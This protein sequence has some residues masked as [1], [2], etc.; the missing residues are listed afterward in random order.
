MRQD[1][2]G[3][4]WQDLPA[5]PG[6]RNMN[7]VMAPIPE[8]GWVTPR[9]FPNLSAAPYIS[10]DTETKDPELISHGPG[11]GRGKGHVVG[12]SVAVPGQAWYFPMRHEVC[13][14]ENM[15]PEHVLAWARDT[16]SNPAQP[17][18]GANLLYDIGWLSEEGVHVQG[19]AHDVQFAESLL[20]EVA[21]VG[22][23][24]LG[25]KY[26]AEGKE[27]NVMYQWSADSYGG[28]ANGDQRA[29]IYRTPPRLVGPYAEEDALLPAKVMPYQWE[30]LHREGLLGL[31]DM[32]CRLIP[33]LIA[34]RKAG[35]AVNISRAEQVRDSLVAREKEISARFKGLL[36]FEISINSASDIFRAFQKLGI[37]VPMKKGD[38]GELKKT[39]A[40]DYL[41]AVDHP[42]VTMLMDARRIEK[43]RSTFIESYILEK[44]VNGK[45]HCQFHP[46]RGD[47]GGARSGRFSSADPNLQNVPIRD[48]ELGPLVR[49]CFVPDFGHKQWRRYDYSQIEYRFMAHF[50]V[51]PGSDE[52]RA[53][54]NNDPDTDYHINTQSLVTNHTGIKV[55]RK[56][57]KN[58]NFGLTF[59]MGKLRL[60]RTLSAELKLVAGG[61]GTFDG[62]S[63]Y[64]AYHDAVPFT[65][66]TLKSYSDL[67][68]SVGFVSTILGRRSRFNLWERDLRWGEEDDGE[69]GGSYP[70]PYA[71][72]LAK[73]GGRI[74][75]SMTHKALNRVLQGSA[76]DCLKKA[77][78][79]MWD[80]GVLHVVG[81]PRLT[82]HDELDFSDAGGNEDAWAYVKHLLE[83]SLPL[84]IPVVA[85]LETGP[86]WGEVA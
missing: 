10:I 85:D 59:G 30:A 23:E 68:R 13:P 27:S 56:P 77:M 79:A 12:I 44:H 55:P 41:A 25:R 69:D 71:A 14:E 49:S 26:L 57:I 45:I 83:N 19:M 48:D 70:L 84:K 11:W 18:L 3:L 31:F 8:T 50:A 34:M 53:Q 86:S 73:W 39:F 62:N 80:S 75:R 21:K 36:G 15:D 74:K 20:D 64:K 67:A 63:F 47:D 7:R 1:S 60:I 33:L 52:L 2:I 5:E 22:L 32:E 17:K 54:Y 29:N 37:P 6:Q 4:F 40:K 9:E 61:V 72:A 43:V 58:L 65:K 35:A 66:E 51:G 78:L 38:N 24:H 42:F 28:K 16:L 82:V 76:A 81:V 46:L